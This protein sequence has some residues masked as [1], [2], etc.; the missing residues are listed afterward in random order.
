MPRAAK[1]DRSNDRRLAHRTH[2]DKR[3]VRVLNRG[4]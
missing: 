1:P 2:S 4:P 3:G